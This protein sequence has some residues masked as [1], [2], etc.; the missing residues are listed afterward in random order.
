MLVLCE[1]NVHLPLFSENM[2][3]HLGREKFST[4]GELRLAADD[5]ICVRRN[6]SHSA[7]SSLNSGVVHES[8]AEVKGFNNK[9]KIEF[10]VCNHTF[11]EAK[12]FH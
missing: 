9:K 8:R 7:V 3:Y 11:S 5:S 12:L 1:F 6:A 4:L 10:S 2:F